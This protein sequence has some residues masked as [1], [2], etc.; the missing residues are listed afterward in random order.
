[1]RKKAQ[2][3]PETQADLERV[4]LDALAG[5]VRLKL[6]QRGLTSPHLARELFDRPPEANADHDAGDPALHVVLGKMMY[7]WNRRS[8]YVDSA[9]RPKPLPTSGPRPSLQSLVEEHADAS[10]AQKVLAAMHNQGLVR[11]SQDGL[12]RPTGNVAQLRSIGPE[13]ASYVADTVARLLDTVLRNLNRDH[14][15]L[16]LIERSAVVRDLPDYLE[17]EFIEFASEQGEL[18]IETINEWL[19]SRRMAAL[20]TRPPAGKPVTAGVQLFSF[21]TALTPAPRPRRAARGAGSSR[22]SSSGART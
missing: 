2:N 1:M 4:A 6:K 9:G 12:N 22:R 21:V 3:R 16:P 17:S 19:E 20:E 14:K 5:L 8:P 18:F 15:D 11:R 7:T 10:A 13:V